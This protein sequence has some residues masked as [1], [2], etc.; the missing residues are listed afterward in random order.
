MY[1]NGP[2]I[3]G[4]TAST[5]VETKRKAYAAGMDAFLLKPLDRKELGTLLRLIMQK[6]GLV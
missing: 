5:N 4:M 6:R 2:M 3:V 1:G